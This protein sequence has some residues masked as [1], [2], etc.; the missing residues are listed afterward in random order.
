MTDPSQSARVLS[1]KTAQVD[2]R[3]I[4]E[5][6]SVFLSTPTIDS[7]VSVVRAALAAQ[8]QAEPSSATVPSDEQIKDS[9]RDLF[10]RSAPDYIV[11]FAR[12]VLALAAPAVQE[13]FKPDW[14]GYRQGVEDG[15]AEAQSAEPTNE[16]KVLFW[17]REAQEAWMRERE[18]QEARAAESAAPAVQAEPTKLSKRLRELAME[19]Q[20]DPSGRWGVETVG[21]MIEAAKFI[22]Q[23]PAAQSADAVDAVAIARKC[24]AYVGEG[25]SFHRHEFDAF[26]AALSQSAAAAKEA[27]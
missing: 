17:M 13:P 1:N 24:G 20:Y 7:I 25:V 6:Q 21:P 2:V 8:P 3:T 19:F 15:M 16:E 12:A 11:E 23:Q 5:A 18:A 14:A 26:V 4:L 9:Y 22:E 27:K 10:G